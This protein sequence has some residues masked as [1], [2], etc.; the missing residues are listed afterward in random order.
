MPQLHPRAEPLALKYRP[1]TFAEVVGQKPTR[2]VLAKMIEQGALPPSMI[3]A[4]VRGTGKTSMA[5]I[6]VKA[7]NCASDGFEP[8]NSCV[9]CVAINTESSPAYVELDAAS[10]GGVDAM[11][12]LVADAQYTSGDAWKVYVL[13]EVHS[14]SRQGF[15]VLL[16]TLEEPP[17]ATSFILV[18]TEPDKI[19]ATIQARS[20]YFRFAPISVA[21]IVG[22][23]VHI[24]GAEGIEMTPDAAI[25]IAEMA[26]GGM[27]D[28]LMMMD[29]A[30]RL[31]VEITREL[32]F[33]MVGNQS[34]GH[35][36]E[37]LMS[38]NPA[39]AVLVADELVGMFGGVGQMIDA[40]IVT[41]RAAL[42]AAGGV[43]VVPSDLRVKLSQAQIIEMIRRLWSM[44]VQVQQL[45]PDQRAAVTALSAEMA[46]RP[47]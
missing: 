42:L 34:V 8:D 24:Q 19:P 16:K 26:T 45:G 35:W 41:L 7:I 37:A 39:K 25:I 9:S 33:G 2:A 21:D 23:I 17:P 10:H 18:T 12:E 22:R 1:R 20:M 47:S 36:I 40:A 31:G 4:G 13:D 29:Q 32:L 14:A 43:G 15:D 44:R 6:V 11:R 5:R 28:A 3:F 30:S 46:R 38:G 27:R